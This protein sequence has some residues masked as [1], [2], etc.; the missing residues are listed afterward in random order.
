L[1]SGIELKKILYNEPNL[2]K[3]LLESLG[4]EHIRKTN[5]KITSTRPDGDN[6]GSVEIRLTETLN[7]KVYTKPEYENTYE[8]QDILTLT[9]FFLDCT[10]GEAANHICKVCDI[11]NSG[12][13]VKKEESP[14]VTFL[15]KYKKILR[16][17]E[18]IEEKV[19]NESVLDQFIH[20]PCKIFTDDKISILTQQFFGVCYDLL[21]NRACFTIFNYKGQLIGVKGRTL[22][23]NYKLL[24]IPKYYVYFEVETNHVLYGEWE[25]GDYLKEADEI[26]VVESEKS[27][28]KAYQMGYRNVVAI[29][30]K[31]ISKQQIRKLLSYGKRIVLAYDK[32]VIEKEI[33]IIARNFKNLV[34]VDYILD[35]YNWLPE[36]SSPLDS[37]KDTFIKML[38]DCRIEY[39]E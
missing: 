35:K 5:D 21:T 28:W 38:T 37:D 4:C 18:E 19:L 22:E 33:K 39:K 12:T 26:I 32:D 30:K 7:C 31:S 6:K 16:N 11:D 20:N 13:Y 3:K 25:N 23:S 27:V 17:D 34:P 9:Q 29:C 8:I 2:I 15:K 14:T 24:G 10:L 1:I 36:K